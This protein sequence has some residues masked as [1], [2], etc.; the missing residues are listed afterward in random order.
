[1]GTIIEIK[2]IV[3]NYKTLYKNVQGNTKFLNNLTIAI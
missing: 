2:D 1:M 3:K